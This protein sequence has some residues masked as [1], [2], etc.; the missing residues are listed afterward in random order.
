MGFTVT[1]T[2]LDQETSLTVKKLWEA[3][4]EELYEH[5]QVTL[6]LF[7]DGKDTGRTETVSLKN[8]WTAVFNGLPYLNEN[9]EP[10]VY[11]VVETWDTDDWIAIYGQIHTI[12][13]GKNPT[14]ETTVTNYYRW[15]DAFELPA[16]GGIGTPIY[17]LCGLTLMLAP[18]VYGFG[19]RRRHRKEA[20]E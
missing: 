11:T 6:K 10:A 16:T 5:A 19:L 3:P 8:G 9:G 4:D 15:S 18:L 2:P 1:N 20:R 17:I 13:G 14:Y 12:S 7:A